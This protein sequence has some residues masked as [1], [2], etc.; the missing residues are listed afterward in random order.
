MQDTEVTGRTLFHDLDPGPDSPYSVSA[1]SN[2]LQKDSLLVPKVFSTWPPIRDPLVTGTSEAQDETVNEC[3][4]FL[5]APDDPDSS[6]VD[7]NFHGIP[8][9]EREKHKAFLHNS[10][11][12]LPA[13]FVAA[14]A[15]RPWML[16]WALS[17][18]QLLGE[19]ISRYRER[20]VS[21][22]TPL[23]NPE[24]GFGGGHGHMSHCAASYAAVLSL[25]MVGGDEALNLINRKTMWKWIGDLKQPDGGFRMCVGGEEDVRGAYCSMVIISLLNLP[26]E[27]PQT[28][29][30][31]TDACATFLS[32]LPEYLSRCQ[33]FEGGI[34]G[35]PNTEAH[36]AYAFY[37]SMS[38]F[39]F[40]GSL[41]AN[42]RQKADSP[43]VPTNL[44]TVATVIGLADAGRSSKQL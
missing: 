5:S 17:G 28:S 16:Y 33:S 18:L 35:S 34:S 32:G 2:M 19:D 43:D 36:G 13:G 11:G 14:D 38:I 8:R 1:S 31:R 21:T 41:L 40:T 10:L 12:N 24:G 37:I 7:F 39:S 29:T 6:L 20:V 15:S 4:P 3:L 25:A 26:M 42:T 9:L 23:Q 22:L 27:L 30:A 44:S